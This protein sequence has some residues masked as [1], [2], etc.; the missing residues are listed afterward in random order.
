M[1]ISLTSNSYSHSLNLTPLLPY[2]QALNRGPSD[3]PRSPYRAAD[4]PTDLARDPLPADG[5]SKTNLL[6]FLVKGMILAMEEHPI[7][8]GRVV[9]K[10]DERWLEIRRDGIVGIA[11][12]GVYESYTGVT[13]S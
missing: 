1:T 6:S 11:V 9:S 7:M 5:D 8:R 3:R 4:I 10:D 2:L 12:S 13:S